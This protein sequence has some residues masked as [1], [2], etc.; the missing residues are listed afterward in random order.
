MRKRD[1]FKY[2][3]HNHDHE[4]QVLRRNQS[5]IYDLRERTV[6]SQLGLGLYRVRTPQ[7]IKDS[8]EHSERQQR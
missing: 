3:Q 5:C 2:E 6:F 4:L 1:L 8:D 7:K